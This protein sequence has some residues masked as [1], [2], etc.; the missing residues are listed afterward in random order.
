MIGYLLNGT[1]GDTAAALS[2]HAD[3]ELRGWRRL[4]VSRHLA[5]CERCGKIYR[6][7]VAT[8]A[9]LRSLAG[10]Q[11]PPSPGIADAVVQRIR[12]R[13]A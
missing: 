4:R 13:D 5:R 7:V 8:I 11:P 12:G 3:G 1:C 2:A 9:G 6:S 10:E